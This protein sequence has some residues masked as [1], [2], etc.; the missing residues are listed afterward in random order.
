MEK[1]MLKGNAHHG[2]YF[3][4]KSGENIYGYIVIPHKLPLHLVSQ[5]KKLRVPG[6][7]KFDKFVIEKEEALVSSSEDN[8]NAIHV[9]GF[10]PQEDN[11]SLNILPFKE[12]WTIQDVASECV[13]VLKEINRIFSK[14]QKQIDERFK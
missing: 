9:I 7:W 12:S 13:Q 11:L 2:I 14:I 10:C 1:V 5:I 4:A 3:V 6:K 8:E